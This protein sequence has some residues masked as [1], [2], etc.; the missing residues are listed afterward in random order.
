MNLLTT[1]DRKSEI[2]ARKNQ[3]SRD[4][5]ERSKLVEVFLCMPVIRA[6]FHPIAVLNVTSAKT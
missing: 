2:F 5:P 4:D 3:N 6:L 1:I